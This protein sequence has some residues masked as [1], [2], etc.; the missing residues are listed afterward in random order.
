[1]N[2]ATWTS[3]YYRRTGR[4]P[5]SIEELRPAPNQPDPKEDPLHD[6]WGHY[7]AIVPVGPGFIVRS[8]GADGIA[9][10]GDDIEYRV[11]HA[12]TER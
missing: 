3:D 7:L 1:M 10:T 9:N 11:T 5:A 2:V 8:P 4:L 6:A 12:A